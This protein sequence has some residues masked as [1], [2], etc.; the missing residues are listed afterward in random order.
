MKSVKTLLLLVA[1]LAITCTNPAWAQNGGGDNPND[2]DW[3]AATAAAI[4]IL[5][6]GQ[7]E[8]AAGTIIW[9]EVTAD[10]VEFVGGDTVTFTGPAGAGTDNSNWIVDLDCNPTPGE[11]N[12]NYNGPTGEVVI[13]PDDADM[14]FGV[15]VFLND[16][17]DPREFYAFTVLENN[18]G[19][20]GGGY[21]G[22]G[23]PNP[24]NCDWDA[25]LADAVG[26]GRVG[27]G[28][29]NAVTSVDPFTFDVTNNGDS[30][31]VTLDDG[32][33]STDNFVF[34][35]GLDC[36]HPDG[37]NWDYLGPNATTVNLPDDGG[38]QFLGLWAFI[39]DDD[40]F[41]HGVT[42]LEGQF[43]P[44]ISIASSSS[45]AIEGE[46]FSLTL[47]GIDSITGASWTKDGSGLAKAISAGGG[48]TDLFVT[49][50]PLELS[51]AGVYCVTGESDDADDSIDE[52]YNLSADDIAAPGSS[53]PVGGMLGLS[54]LSI[55][56]A[57][58]GMQML[59][60]R[61]LS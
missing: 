46:A 14:E 58:A 13:L 28:D 51:D 8:R 39:D 25:L 3:E 47:S 27:D 35:A 49:F 38:G 53:V 12:R 61:Q 20:G 32:H 1:A 19:G 30:A 52:C 48:S 17:A 37:G 33:S 36:Q 26:D 15:W 56:I 2:C 18:S 34:I 45:F 41:M 55:L 11:D 9:G 54:V 24:N 5:F 29:L 60:R 4:P 43:L 59:R 21:G 31:T 57:L 10:P 40:G 23:T 6:A 50:D 16:D 42:V 44:P 22:D 7:A